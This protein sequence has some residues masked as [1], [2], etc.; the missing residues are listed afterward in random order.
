MKNFC[1][2]QNY[3]PG[4]YFFFNSTSLYTH[5]QKKLVFLCVN[6]YKKD[7]LYWLRELVPHTKTFSTCR[8]YK[9][10]QF[11]ENLIEE[12]LKRSL[13]APD[14]VYK[15]IHEFDLKATQ[16]VSLFS[17]SIDSLSGKA[18]NYDRKLNQ[19]TP[20]KFSLLVRANRKK[21]THNLFAFPNSSD[22][23]I[24]ASSSNN[25]VKQAPFRSE[26]IIKCPDDNYQD[27]YVQYLPDELK[28]GDI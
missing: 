25:L 20:F 4:D 27:N 6:Y 19:A 15:F 8:H 2:L 23:N 24:Y 28:E 21:K 12:T 17:F 9:F 1:S 14:E 13:P 7:K 5:F 22:N 10:V 18:L 3:L 26:I 16:S 11:I